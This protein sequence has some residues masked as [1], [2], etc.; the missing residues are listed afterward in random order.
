MLRS[1][2]QHLSRHIQQGALSTRNINKASVSLLQS[3]KMPEGM[4]SFSSQPS[5]TH[6]QLTLDSMNPNLRE[7]QYAVRGEIVLRAME[8]KAAL[9]R[10][11]HRPFEKVIHC[12]IGNP[13]ELGQKPLT[14]PREVL[15]LLNFPDLLDNPKCAEIF[16][17]EA[18][19]RAQFY[20]ERIPGG[21][22]AYS[23]SQ[24]KSFASSHV[25]EVVIKAY[26]CCWAGVECVREEVA[27][28]LQKRDGYAATS[29]NIFLTDGASPG[30]QAIIRAIIRNKSD[31]VMIPIPQYPLYSAS[32]A[33]YGGQSVGYELD[34]EAD[35]GTNTN[36]LYS[37]YAKAAENGCNVRA[38]AVINPGNPTGGCLSEQAMK[39]LLTFCHEKG[40]V[41]MADEV[42]QDNIWTDEKSWHSF[43]K[44]AADMGLIDPNNPLDSTRNSIQLVSFHSVSKGYLGECGRRGGYMELIGFD[45]DVKQEIYKL[46][47]ISLC[48]NVVGQVSVSNAIMF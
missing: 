43:K 1:G 29:G 23:N 37:S 38:I 40:L 47:S 44:V 21:V 16:S 15:A 36:E 31:G 9:D 22:G 17:Q 34:E 12:N 32:L 41:L 26:C 45:E 7:A 8:H 6:P 42:Y 20:N 46:A 11:E 39:S 30:V 48:S 3:T 4:A 33:L 10:G 2:V 28:F 13:Q 24:G 19:R 27:E 25:G 5:N 14:F 35:W 18:I